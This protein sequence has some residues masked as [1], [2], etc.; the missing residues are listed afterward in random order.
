MGMSI[1]IIIIII[2]I[3]II[4]IMI[5]IIIIIIINN[6]NNKFP[7][8]AMMFTLLP[9]SKSISQVGSKSFRIYRHV[10]RDGFVNGQ[11]LIS[12]TNDHLEQ[13]KITNIWHRQAILF[14][15]AKLRE[16]SEQLTS[17]RSD[18]LGEVIARPYVY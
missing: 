17:G 5:I 4:T 14:A 2:T 15:V 1:V 10:F 3:I 12:I 11:M 8:C 18:S 13:Q 9:A 16:A 7:A 6:N